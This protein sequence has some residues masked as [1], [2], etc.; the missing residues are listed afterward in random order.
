MTVFL[1]F[2]VE[3]LPKTVERGSLWSKAPAF[4][5][6]QFSARTSQKGHQVPAS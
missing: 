6:V 2:I 4:C 1:I 5:C 3:N